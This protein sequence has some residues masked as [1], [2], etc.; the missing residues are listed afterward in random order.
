VL[1]CS[2]VNT[3]GL[4]LQLI[5]VAINLHCVRLSSSFSTAGLAWR[6]LA[7]K[8]HAPSCQPA[9]CAAASHELGTICPALLSRHCLATATC[10]CTAGSYASCH[11]Q[12]QEFACRRVQVSAADL[13]VI[14]SIQHL[15]QPAAATQARNK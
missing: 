11:I 13:A 14:V 8:H 2:I 3:A 4:R 1:T 6:S 5:C 10:C 12:V 9:A 15:A 7:C